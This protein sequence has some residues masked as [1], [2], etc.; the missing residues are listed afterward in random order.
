MFFFGCMSKSKTI[1]KEN[2]EIEEDNE[3]NENYSVITQNPNKK[4]K[5]VKNITG[6]IREE[7]IKS[8]LKEDDSIIKDIESMC[9]IIGHEI[10]KQNIL[11][12]NITN[13]LKV[14][15]LI[16]KMLIII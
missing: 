6:D 3:I 7:E 16:L 13:L 14:I 5:F 8:N 4:D 9:I 10:D 15:I 11:I 1:I 12:D 2:I